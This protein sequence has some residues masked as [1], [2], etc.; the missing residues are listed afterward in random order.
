MRLIVSWLFSECPLNCCLRP[1]NESPAHAVVHT[2]NCVFCRCRGVR[3]RL[4]G[5]L[6]TIPKRTPRRRLTGAT[7]RL[8]GVS[9]CLTSVSR[10]LTG[11]T[12]R[13]KGVSRCLTSVSRRL[14]G[15]T[16]RLKGVSK[17]LTS[18]SR[19]LTDATRRLKGVSR[20]L[21]GALKTV[22]KRAPNFF[23]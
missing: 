16:R 11:A 14:T 13:L 18:V 3:R 12:R 17:C 9:R 8:K 5:A 2:C 10:R 6:K 22:P 19:R 15:A 21:T 4:T 7:R 1:L 20:R 23:I